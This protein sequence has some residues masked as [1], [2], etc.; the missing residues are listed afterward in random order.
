MSVSVQWDNDE[1]SVIYYS[2][3]D[4]WKWIEV[5]QAIDEIFAMMDGVDHV[6]DA[7]VHFKSG[8]KIKTGMLTEGRRLLMRQHTR[9]GMT[10]VVTSNALFRSVYNMIRVTYPRANLYTAF[11]FAT[12][13]DEARELIQ[14]R[15]QRQETFES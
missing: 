9:S 6:V 13:L 15:R 3:D 11:S 7:I 5:H 10:V 2:I 1:K 4:P 12:T 8:I 14:Q